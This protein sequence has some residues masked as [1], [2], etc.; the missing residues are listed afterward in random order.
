MEGKTHILAAVATYVTVNNY[1]NHAQAVDVLNLNSTPLLTFVS[2]GAM[3]VGSIMPDMDLPNSSISNKI[4]LVNLKMVK[5]FINIFLLFL[6]VSILFFV[7]NRYLMYGGIGLLLFFFLSYAKLARG[8]LQIA[9][10]GIQILLIS[11]LIIG[12]TVK[13]QMPLLLI[14]LTLCCYVLS[15]HRGISHTLFLNGIA[16]F[17]AYYSLNYY[18]YDDF[19]MNVSTY[20][21]IGTFVHVYLNDFFTN[22]GV[23]SPLYPLSTII[24]IPKNIMDRGFTMKAMKE[25]IKPRRVKFLFTIETGG[26][27]EVAFSI[28]CIGI[29]FFAWV[30]NFMR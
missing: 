19:A 9:R 26:T 23:P 16:A 25:G 10:R 24:T 20:F 14:A 2:L 6:S 22:K 30:T 12:Y 8:I 5:I 1:F 28:V 7:G 11:S 4:T 27:V 15:K 29:I 13:G 17:C 21:F 18:G 3:I